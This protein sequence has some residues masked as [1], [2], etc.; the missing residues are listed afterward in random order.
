MGAGKTYNFYAEDVLWS[1]DLVPFGNYLNEH[2]VTN[3][4]ILWSNQKEQACE[5]LPDN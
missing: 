1:L 2:C 4:D 5:I 3:T